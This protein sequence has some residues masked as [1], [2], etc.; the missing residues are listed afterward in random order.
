[1]PPSRAS[2]APT[3]A[4]A[5]D[6][7]AHEAPSEAARQDQDQGDQDRDQALEPDAVGAWDAYRR[8]HQLVDTEVARDLEQQSGLS[9]PDY[10]VLAALADMATPDSCIRVRRL[11]AHLHWAHSRL[12]RHLGRMEARGL[13]A[14]E[15]CERDGR[16]DDV[17]LTAEGREAY[18][19]ATPGYRASV[20]RH[21]SGPLSTD[22]RSALVAIERTIRQ[23][24]AGRDAH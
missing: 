5:R 10:E 3:P 21:F 20:R 9:M 4:P 19:R 11:A 16:G 12:S 13:I 17:V 6:A 22:Q 18:D 23:T 1:M 14:R 8:L 24:L 15:P 7:S 2:A